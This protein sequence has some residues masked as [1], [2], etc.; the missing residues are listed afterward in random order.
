MNLDQILILGILVVM[1]VLFAMNRIRFELVA[2]LALVVSVLLGLVP[3]E[4]AF[5]GFSNGAVVTVAGVLVMSRA[6]EETGFVEIIADRIGK[7]GSSVKLQIA[8]LVVGVT[9]FSAFM[10]NIGALALFM[11][12]A[13]GLA[14]K[15]GYSPSLSLMPLAFGSLFGG[16]I[17]LIGTPPNII[18]SNFRKAEVGEPFGMFDFAPVGLAVSIASILIIVFVA[19]RLIPERKSKGTVDEVFR[20]KDYTSSIVVTE[21][22]LLNGLRL[23][24]LDRTLLKDLTVVGYVREGQGLV[25]PNLY[26]FMKPKDRLIVESTADSLGLFLKA[27]NSVLSDHKEIESSDLEN[28]DFGL[29]EASV[30]P[31]SAFLWKTAKDL[32]LR[33]KYHVNLLAISRQG[34]RLK[35]APNR[36]PFQAGDVLLIQGTEGLVREMLNDLGGLPLAARD[37]RLHSSGKTML[38][39]SIFVAALFVVALGI[40]GSEIVFTLAAVLMVLVGVIKPSSALHAIDLPTL[41]LLGALIPVSQALETTGTAK[42]IASELVKLQGIIPPWGVLMVLM[43][44]SMLLTNI[45]NNAAAAMLLAPIAIGLAT[46]SGHSIDPYL[47]T[48]CI[49][50]SAAFMTPIGHASCTVIMGPGGYKFSDYW[51]PGLVVSV[52]TLLVSI[53]VILFV[54]PL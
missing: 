14:R 46:A 38:C 31:N 29:F 32:D 54:F 10:N 22:S 9:L 48:V 35:N 4:N 37:L 53:P 33:R 25:E 43:T 7:Y 24:D 44:M 39:L 42:L 27:T 8:L 45:I 11:P 18:I 12:V 50:S 52:V 49:G 15:N 3:K 16:M 17:T 51:K 28:E 34:E 13:I 21:E 2:L 23:K 19:L 5:N 1:L 6:L 30:L 36:V 47:M 20:I 26:R 41:F 40:L